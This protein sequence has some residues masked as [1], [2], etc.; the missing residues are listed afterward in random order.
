LGKKSVKGGSTEGGGEYRNG[1]GLVKK[2]QGK[3][4]EKVVEKGSLRKKG[5]RMEK[6]SGVFKEWEKKTWGKGGKWEGGTNRKI[7]PNDR[8]VLGEKKSHC[9]GEFGSQGG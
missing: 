7:T 6:N 2:T 5:I 3:S 9:S 8:R 4:V 1:W